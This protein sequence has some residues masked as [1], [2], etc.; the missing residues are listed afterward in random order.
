MIFQQADNRRDL[1]AV[2]GRFAQETGASVIAVGDSKTRTGECTYRSATTTA[3]GKMTMYDL[4]ATAYDRVT[5][6]KLGD[7]LFP[8]PKDCLDSFSAKVGTTIAPGSTSYVDKEAVAKWA[9]TFAR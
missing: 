6:R 2:L 3:T 8:A 4:H 5:G 1:R 9:A 7:R